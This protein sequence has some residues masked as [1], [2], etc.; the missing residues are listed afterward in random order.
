MG[1][2]FLPIAYLSIK[3]EPRKCQQLILSFIGKFIS[4]ETPSSLT[5]VESEIIRYAQRVLRPIT[6]QDIAQHL[7]ISDRHAR[8]LL[9][10][11][12]DSQIQKV[13]SGKERKRTYQ[14]K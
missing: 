14:L 1:W 6:P 11:M 12:V 9:H 5:W 4:I 13:V 2:M 7:H 3:D 10:K 8:R